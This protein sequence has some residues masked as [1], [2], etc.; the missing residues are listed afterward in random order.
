[1]AD[2]S[3]LVVHV[4]SL[5]SRNEGFGGE[6]VTKKRNYYR[7]PVPYYMGKYDMG[8]LYFGGLTTSFRRCADHV[9]AVKIA[10]AAG[11]GRGLFTTKV[12]R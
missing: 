4:E 8:A 10:E 3:F 12:R 1:M 6:G 5:N 9:G 7:L 2:N 11:C